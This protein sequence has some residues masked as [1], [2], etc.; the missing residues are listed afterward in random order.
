MELL[1]APSYFLSTKGEGEDEE[2]PPPKK[3][4]ISLEIWNAL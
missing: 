1:W 4:K 2:V 3:W